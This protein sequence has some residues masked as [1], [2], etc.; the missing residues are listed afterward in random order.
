[1]AEDKKSVKDRLGISEDVE[2]EIE[3]KIGEKVGDVSGSADEIYD[4][5]LGDIDNEVDIEVDRINKAQVTK[6]VRGVLDI[7]PFEKSELNVALKDVTAMSVPE[8][9]GV[10]GKVVNIVILGIG[11]IG[12]LA[13]LAIRWKGRKNSDS[14]SVGVGKDST[15]ERVDEFNKDYKAP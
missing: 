6:S 2:S 7:L 8:V 15:P 14:G 5:I 10:N 11:L 4:D 3:E 13:P 9:F 1:M 12:L